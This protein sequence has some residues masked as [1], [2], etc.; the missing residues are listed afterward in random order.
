MRVIVLIS[1]A[2]ALFVTGCGQSSSSTSQPATNTAQASDTANSV[3]ATPNYGGVLGQAQKYSIGQIDLAQLKQ[4][5]QQFNA[6]EGRHPKDL[7]ELVPNYLAKIPTAPPGYKISY[8]PASGNV[9]V[10]QQ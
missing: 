9:K 3:N 4:A 8:D 7:Q 5:I 2:A 6:A 10:A 1:V